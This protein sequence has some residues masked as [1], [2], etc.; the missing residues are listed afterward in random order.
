MTFL[1]AG[2]LTCQRW[3][4]PSAAGTR[5]Y[6]RERFGDHGGEAR[7]DFSLGAILND[8]ALPLA[9]ASQLGLDRHDDGI[10]IGPLA[11]SFRL[12]RRGDLRPAQADFDPVGRDGSQSRR[13]WPPPRPTARCTASGSRLT[14]VGI[15]VRWN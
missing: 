2:S 3:L 13:L 5:S 11:R 9:D 6:D 7:V 10:E 15:F 4:E 14:I 1:V 8:E 12:R